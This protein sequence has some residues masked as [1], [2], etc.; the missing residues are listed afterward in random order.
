MLNPATRVNKRLVGA[1][2][3]VFNEIFIILKIFT[4]H[5]VDRLNTNKSSVSFQGVKPIGFLNDAHF[6]CKQIQK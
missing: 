1:T 2:G 5:F 6:V 3:V 4:Q